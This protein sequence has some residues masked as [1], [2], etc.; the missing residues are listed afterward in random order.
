MNLSQEEFDTLVAAR[1]ILQRICVDD[2]DSNTVIAL[3]VQPDG[4][5][6]IQVSQYGLWIRQ[7]DVFSPIFEEKENEDGS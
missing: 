6:G 4:V 1:K 2:N 7:L 5:G 3:W